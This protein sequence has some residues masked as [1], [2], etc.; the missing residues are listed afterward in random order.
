[1]S[2]TDET[3]S[4]ECDGSLHVL[5]PESLKELYND[6]NELTELLGPGGQ[7]SPMPGLAPIDI[8]TL[9]HQP[10][11]AYND[12]ANSME[13]STAGLTKEVY[14]QHQQ[15][16]GFVTNVDVY[17]G[18]SDE[19]A[20][21]P[22]GTNQTYQGQ[23]IT[24]SDAVYSE[25][26]GRVLGTE[27]PA[28][29][30]TN[31]AYQPHYQHQLQDYQHQQLLSGGGLLADGSGDGAMY[32]EPGSVISPRAFQ[33]LTAT[34]P[35]SPDSSSAN[36]ASPRNNEQGQN[37]TF[38]RHARMQLRVYY[39]HLSVTLKSGTEI[40]HDGRHEIHNPSGFVI[41]HDRIRPGCIPEDAVKFSLPL[42][43]KTTPDPAK[44]WLPS[45]RLNP[46]D[47]D[48][49]KSICQEMIGGLHVQ[50]DNGCIYATRYS[51]IQVYFWS[52]DSETPQTETKKLERKQKTLVFD[53]AAYFSKVAKLEGN[54]DAIMKE[55]LPVIVFT[56]GFPWVAFSS[57]ALRHTHIH[58]EVTPVAAVQWL[59]NLSTGQN[60]SIPK[61][62]I[63]KEDIHKSNDPL[64]F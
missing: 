58:I 32:S 42:E 13:T 31:I 44:P 52:N 40:S 29:S 21:L 18:A 22:N 4:M 9:L 56:F 27:I 53:Y 24:S 55:R 8:A 3:T 23:F 6:L 11:Q 54:R 57:T 28:Q 47:A 64:S 59:G 26:S 48:T 41:Y 38:Q 7:A 43:A 25:A 46:D 61:G 20:A 60:C 63:K 16:Q 51:P 37:C 34:N 36:H 10:H 35:V 15:Q 14:A 50:Y 30:Q 33:P 39:K 19:A 5:G 12:A 49:I 45:V 2:Q 1:M 17:S 62:S